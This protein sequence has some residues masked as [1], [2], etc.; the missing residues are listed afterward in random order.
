MS[1]MTGSLR[2]SKPC[3]STPP[4]LSNHSVWDEHARY[5]NWLYIYIYM[6]THLVIGSLG[7]K[8]TRKSPFHPRMIT[9]KDA[10]I[11]LQHLSRKQPQ[12]L[13]GDNVIIQRFPEIISCSSLLNSYRLNHQTDQFAAE[14]LCTLA[15]QSS[16][17][18]KVQHHSASYICVWR[19][20]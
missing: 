10:R 4:F 11:V 13:C 7:A 5:I 6:F 20:I 17:H 9:A 14:T 12:G 1:S 18:L 2:T 15:L 19:Y 3:L 8:K 16:W